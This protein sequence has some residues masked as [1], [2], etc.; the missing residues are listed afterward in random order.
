MRAR[1][2]IL[3]ANIRCELRE[4]VLKDK[5]EAM[6]AVSNKGTVPVLQTLEEKI[7][8]QSLEVMHWALQQHDAEDWL[9]VDDESS[10]LID[11][12]DTQFKYYLDRYKYH[13]AYPEQPQQ[14]YRDKAC[15]FLDIIERCLE[16]NDGLAISRKKISITDIAIFPF[17]RQFANVDID[18]FT[19]SPYVLI[20]TWYKSLEQSHLFQNSMQKYEQWLPGH[21]PVYFPA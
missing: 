18:W 16:V 4:V 19:S 8:D 2:A 14:F 3:Q 6:L 11:K 20:K 15:Q 10:A 7:I 1:M 5:P 21:K 9:L 13:V 12:N 17:I